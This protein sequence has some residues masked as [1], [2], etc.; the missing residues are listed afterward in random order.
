MFKALQFFESDPGDIHWV[1]YLLYPTFYLLQP[2]HH[3][4]ANLDKSNGKKNKEGLF[5]L[6]SISLVHFRATYQ[7][8]S[9]GTTTM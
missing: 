9:W 3:I 4:V 5:S 8:K 1:S 7:A 2:F 6:L